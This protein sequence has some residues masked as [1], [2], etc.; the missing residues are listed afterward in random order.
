MRDMEPGGD[1]MATAGCMAWAR[2]TRCVAGVGILKSIVCD[3]ICMLGTEHVPIL[4][5]KKGR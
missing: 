1:P 4:E 3:A 2:V 5:V